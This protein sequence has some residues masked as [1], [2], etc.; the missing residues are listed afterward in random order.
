MSLTVEPVTSAADRE[1]IYAFRYRVYVEELGMTSQANHAKQ[2][3]HDDQ[4]EHSASFAV[5]QDGRVVGSLRC[6]RLADLPDPAPL[7]AKF[8]MQP[9]LETYDPGEIGTSSRFIVDRSRRGGA[10][11]FRLIKAGYDAGRA[12]GV[13]LNFGDCSPHLLPFYEHLGYRRYTVGYNDDAYGYKVPILMLMGD[14]E[15]F[16]RVRSPLART[17]EKAEDDAEARAWFG[18]VYAQYR[19]LQ[20]ATFMPEDVFFDVMAERLASDPLH[21]MSLLRGLDRAE[22]EK[23]LARATLIKLQ[24]GD[25]IVRRGDRDNTLYVLLSG[26]AEVATADSFS[27]PVAM[28][29]AG[30]TFGEIGYLTAVPR[31]AN[32]VARR[33]SEV[34][35]L[36]GDFLERLIAG[37][38]RIGAKILLNLSRELAG[39]LAV[40]TG[41]VVAAN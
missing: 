35:V 11:V 20:S 41:R 28:F 29:G 14:H 4:D 1:E 26:L 27:P 12:M 21:Q 40:M 2:W 25:L 36:S 22:A 13:R 10:A 9:A 6:T 17:A 16:R 5:K 18:A 7:I 31:T 19:D 39:R 34:L 8:R 37:E 30:D 3:L 23:F 24:P 15:H 38:P 32:V 33:E